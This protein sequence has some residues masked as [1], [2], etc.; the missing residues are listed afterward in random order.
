M[1]STARTVCFQRCLPAICTWLCLAALIGN[2]QAQRG[3]RPGG[4][5]DRGL[6]GGHG[7]GPGHNMG[8]GS[9]MGSGFGGGNAPGFPGGMP[10][11]R[12]NSGNSGNLAV[13]SYSTYTTPDPNANRAPASDRYG[14][15][16]GLHGPN[17][18]YHHS[19][20]YNYG[21]GF[22]YDHGYGYSNRG[23]GVG[24]Y[25]SVPFGY[26]YNPYASPYGVYSRSYYGY[27]NP[28]LYG[29]SPSPLG[30]VS[31]YYVNPYG[32]SGAFADPFPA[33]GV[34]TNVPPAAIPAAEVPRAAPI[35][36]V[37]ANASDFQSRAEQAFREHRFEEAA[38]LS[39]HATVEDPQNGK[40][41]LFAA[42][43]KFAL[44]EYEAAA[45]YVHRAASLLDRTEWGYVV[46]NYKQFYRGQDYVTQMNR[47]VSYCKD[48]PRAAYAH[49]L[50]G[51][52]Y[53]YLGYTNSARTLLAA[54][55]KMEP[56]DQLAADLLSML[57]SDNAPAVPASVEDT[58]ESSS[59]IDDSD[60]GETLPA[61]AAQDTNANSVLINPPNPAIK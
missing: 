8:S 40:L 16:R 56:Q 45:G 43:S 52:Q 21:H 5:H 60:I 41:Y 61:P 7:Q 6:S 29:S 20:D 23:S 58:P 50:R 47:L 32:T 44:G 42:Q 15:H 9:E 59:P 27:R 18:G 26:G 33:S 39:D 34:V 24:V 12:G 22:N 49:F 19:H 4:G 10:R 54:A 11:A 38:R 51:Y 2:A 25:L 48:N 31:G 14:S 1:Q 3:N 35:I 36:A 46:E 13:E 53:K 55:L 57:P 17:H 37:A 28:Y 30:G